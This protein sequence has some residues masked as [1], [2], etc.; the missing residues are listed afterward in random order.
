[1]NSLTVDTLIQDKRRKVTV[2]YIVNDEIQHYLIVR[3]ISGDK[4]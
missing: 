1:M 3:L 4:I 2:V